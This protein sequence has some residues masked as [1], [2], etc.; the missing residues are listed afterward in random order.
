MGYN[1]KST[2]TKEKQM[3]KLIANVK[4][5]PKENPFLFAACVL[6]ATDVVRKAAKK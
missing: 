2:Q 4:R 3:S 6:I 1:E 5:M